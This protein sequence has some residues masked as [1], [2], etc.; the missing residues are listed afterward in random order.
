[1]KKQMG[2][3]IDHRRAVIVTVSSSGTVLAEILSEVEKQ[4]R[5]AGDSPLKGSYEAHQVPPDGNRNRAFKKELNAYYDEVI[6]TLRE[7][8]EILIFGPGMAKTELKSRLESAKLGERVLALETTD[9][10]TDTEITE[11]VRRRFA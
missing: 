8:E 4:P 10:M 3:W 6:D 1:M 9:K 7:A 11:K 5:R 2:L